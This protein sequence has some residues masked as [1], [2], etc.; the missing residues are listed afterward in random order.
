[1]EQ[2]SD[3][4]LIAEALDGNPQAFTRLVER[5]QDRYTRFAVRM[6]GNRQD[7]DDALQRAF[8]RAHRSLG[9]CR[10]RER[11]GTWLYSIVANQC[12]TLATRRARWD[13][14]FVADEGALLSARAEPEIDVGGWRE[15]IELALNR[16]DAAQREAFLMKHVEQLDYEEMSV[17]T[18]ASV[19]ALK[20]RVKRA[21]DR[22]HG[23]LK[24]AMHGGS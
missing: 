16:L 23:L 19:S 11:F 9:Q 7:A 6:L 5:Y 3:A 8:L 14:R 13:R 10:D 17:I 4:A 1:M 24:E 21:C 15:E 12:R 18:G 20:M 2:G 22:L